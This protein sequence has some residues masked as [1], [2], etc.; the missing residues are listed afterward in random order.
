MLSLEVWDGL[1]VGIVDAENSVSNLEQS[2]AGSPRKDL[3]YN[4][5]FLS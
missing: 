2:L 1:G 4:V 5:V 3:Q